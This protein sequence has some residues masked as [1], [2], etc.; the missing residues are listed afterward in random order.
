MEAVDPA[1]VNT[2]WLATTIGEASVPLKS[3]EPASTEVV[4]LYRLAPLKV[5]VPAPVLLSPPVP[6][7]TPVKV[8]E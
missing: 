7:M 2:A 3:I 6:E 1:P 8:S 4:P 5:S